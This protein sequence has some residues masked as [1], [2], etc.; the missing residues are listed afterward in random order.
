MRKR[1]AV[2]G[3]DP[4]PLGLVTARTKATLSGGREPLS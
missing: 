3:K 1:F 2:A 4:I